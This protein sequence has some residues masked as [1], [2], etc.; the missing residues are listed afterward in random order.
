MKANPPKS[1]VLQLSCVLVF[2]LSP[3]QQLDDPSRTFFCG[4]LRVYGSND[5][6]YINISGKHAFWMHYFNSPSK[7]FK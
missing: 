2:G 7:P 3:S 6:K 5:S 1:C 4:A